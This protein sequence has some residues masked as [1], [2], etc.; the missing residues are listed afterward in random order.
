MA[1]A[2]TTATGH[3]AEQRVHVEENGARASGG[4]HVGQ[5]MAGKGLSA[6]HREH[7]D[8][9]RDDGDDAP[10]HDGDVHRVA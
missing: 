7:P 6:H 8:D 2:P 1:P 5:R 3:E 10:D 4:R 9:G